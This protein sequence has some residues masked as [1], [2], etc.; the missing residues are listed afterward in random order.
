[1]AEITALR[2]TFASCPVCLNDRSSH[3]AK[4]VQFCMLRLRHN[5]KVARRVI[6]SVAID[7]VD[8]LRRC[9]RAVQKTLHNNSVFRFVVPLSNHDVSVAVFDVD[10]SENLVPNRFPIASIQGV[11]VS[12]KALGEIRLGASINGTGR[13]RCLLGTL[14]HPRVTMSVPSFVVQHAP[15]LGFDFYLTLTSFNRTQHWRSPFCISLYSAVG[16][17]SS[18][19]GGSNGSNFCFSE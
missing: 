18:A 9:Q 8:M 7:V 11:V 14:D 13:R 15:P 3:G 2:P 19:I 12:A 1:M 6:Q 17:M 5:L 10:A 4:V 16:I